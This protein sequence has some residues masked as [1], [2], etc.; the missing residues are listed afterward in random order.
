MLYHHVKSVA[1]VRS[2]QAACSQVGSQVQNTSLR[3][4]QLFALLLLYYRFLD[5]FKTV[6]K[7]KF[8]SAAI[9]A[10]FLSVT[11]LKG[12]P[13]QLAPM[14]SNWLIR[15]QVLMGWSALQG[16]AES[17]ASELADPTQVC[18]LLS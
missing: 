9:A 14:S 16:S 10:S 15:H 7:L 8:E 12:V 18:P 13:G 5:R 4:Q 3:V 11:E 6:D 2:F 1:A 17:I